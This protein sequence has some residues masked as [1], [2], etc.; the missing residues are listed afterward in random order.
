[1]MEVAILPEMVLAGME[2]L[3]ESKVR[4]LSADD[5]AI[6]VYLAMEAVRQVAIL[7]SA[8]RIVH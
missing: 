6:A 3:A 5:T 4:E 2:A 7:K 1:M 8:D